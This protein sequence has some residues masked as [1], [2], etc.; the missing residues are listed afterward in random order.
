MGKRM[1]FVRRLL[2]PE[3]KTVKILHF[4]NVFLDCP[5]TDIEAE[6]S[7]SYREQKRA[8]FRH[9]VEWA[10]NNGVHFI[11]ITVCDT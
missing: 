8:T 1:N 11:L 3:K 6:A 7:A 2:M 10:A 4:G 9:A 5:T